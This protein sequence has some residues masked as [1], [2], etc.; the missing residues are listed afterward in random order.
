MLGDDI[1]EKD[2]ATRAQPMHYAWQKT[3]TEW[4]TRRKSCY[5]MFV[6]YYPNPH[7]ASNEIQGDKIPSGYLDFF[8]VWTYTK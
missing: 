3:R 7:T 1:V 2:R 5:T 4:F 6:H 8:Y